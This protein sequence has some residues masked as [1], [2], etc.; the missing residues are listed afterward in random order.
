[1]ERSGTAQRGRREFL[2]RGGAA[3]VL[4]LLVAAGLVKPEAARAAE[5]GRAGFDAKTVEEVFAA[6]GAKAPRASADVA[7]EAPDLAENGGMVPVTVTSGLPGTR[8]IAIVAEQNPTMLVAV[9]S[10][11]EGTV[12]SIST[13]IKMARTSN[14]VALVEAGGEL[15]LA[16]REVKVTVGGCG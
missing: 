8:R 7:L 3:T 16:R 12:P 1:M 5:A 13:R 2:E 9:F 14:V 4:G 10:L 11:P 6:L 15:L